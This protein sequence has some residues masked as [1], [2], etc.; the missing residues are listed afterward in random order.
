MPKIGEI[1]KSPKP[2]C[3]HCGATSCYH[4]WECGVN[5]SEDEHVSSCKS[6]PLKPPVCKACEGSGKASSGEKCYP[7]KG[8]GVQNGYEENGGGNR[9]ESK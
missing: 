3:P 8:T 5:V 2:T 9:T 4:C 7:C 1:K 6:N